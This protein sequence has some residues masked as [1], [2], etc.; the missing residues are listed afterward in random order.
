MATTEDKKNNNGTPDDEHVAPEVE[1]STDA[2]ET[3]SG[4]DEGGPT[5]GEEKAE[6][7]AGAFEQAQTE[8]KN[9]LGELRAE[10]GALQFEQTGARVRSWVEEN[11]VLASLLAVG[12][13]ILLGK[14]LKEAFRPAPPP[15][16][17]ER[18]RRQLRQLAAEAESLAHETGDV[19]SDRASATAHKL[20]AIAADTGETISRHSHEWGDAVSHAATKRAAQAK[21]AVYDAAATA[22]SEAAHGFS[23]A[24]GALNAAKAAFAAV[25]AKRVTDWVRG[26]R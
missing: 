9:A 19:L 13:G 11:P 25:V 1:T 23:A 22:R 10:L 17:T 16:L 15:T 5:I 14:L 12:G 18:A 21:G 2:A 24:E 26:I 7:L 4:T 8:M 6:E 3:P 20:R